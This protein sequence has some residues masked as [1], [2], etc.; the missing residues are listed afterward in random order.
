MTEP[1][2][3]AIDGPVASGKTVV[4]RLLAQRLGDIVEYGSIAVF[5]ALEQIPGGVVLG[6]DLDGGWHFSE[7]FGFYNVNFFPAWLF[8]LEHG[9]MFLADGGTTAAVWMVHT[10]QYLPHPVVIRSHFHR[11]Y[12]LPGRRHEFLY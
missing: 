11:Q 8:H 9:W 12:S 7:W 4:G 2:A 5:A 10:G 3:I 1:K 6:P